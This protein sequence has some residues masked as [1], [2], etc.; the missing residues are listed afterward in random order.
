[1][2][3]KHLAVQDA[4]ISLVSV[5]ENIDETPSGIRDDDARHPGLH[6]RVLFAEPGPRSPQRHDPESA[7][8]GTS[9]K[10]PLG[11][12][13]VRTTDARGRESRVIQVDPERADLVRFAF[14]ATPPGTG[15]C[16][17]WPRN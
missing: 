12:L 3:K 15:P 14:T 9:T 7:I 5:T 1:M 2:S 10:A 4:N 17:A 8:G 11:Y 13:N 16:R 6:G